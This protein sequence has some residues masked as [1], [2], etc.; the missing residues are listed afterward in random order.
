MIIWNY[1]SNLLFWILIISNIQVYLFLMLF[2]GRRWKLIDNSKCL[3]VLYTYLYFENEK[4]PA[5]H[6][7]LKVLDRRQNLDYN[8]YRI[9]LRKSYTFIFGHGRSVLCEQ[10]SSLHDVLR[11]QEKHACN[12]FFSRYSSMLMQISKFYSTLTAKNG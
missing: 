12:T 8:L 6:L 11:N 7:Y 4:P 5:T 10:T 1:F 9:V 3:L 2:L